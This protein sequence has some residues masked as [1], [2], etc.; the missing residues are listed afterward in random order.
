MQFINL[1]KLEQLQEIEAASFSKPQI[2][3]KHSTRCSTSMMAKR[4]LSSQM[5]NT[6]DE[7]ADIYY[8]DLIEFREISNAIASKFN[9]YHESPQI[10]LIKNGKCVFDASHSDVSLTNLLPSL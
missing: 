7:L 2:L 3:F 1:N 9:V 5:Q 6:A 10:L 4:I 8:L